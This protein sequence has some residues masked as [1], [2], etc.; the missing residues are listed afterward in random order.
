MAYRARSR[1]WLVIVAALAVCGVIA[2]PAAAQT[3][4]T[5]AIAAASVPSSY[6]EAPGPHAVT[7][8]QGGPD[9]TLYYPTNLG[10]GGTQHP[11][12]IWGNGTGATPESYDAQLRHLAT[13]GFVVAAANTT[14]SGSGQE[15]LAGAR[16]LIAEDQRSGSVFYGKI[17]ETKIGAAGHS[18]GGGGTIAAGADPIVDTTIPIQPGPQGSVP[19]LKG[20]SL[21]VAGQYDY[22]VPSWYVKSRYSQAGHVPAIFAELRGSDHF[23]PGETRVRLIGVVTAWFRFWL[24]ADEQARGIFFGPASSCGI[25]NDRAAWSAVARNSRAQAIPG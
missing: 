6:Y 23:F 1:S 24:A 8:V 2:S 5:R 21:F 16:F 19:Q 7:K 10:A 14:Q 9:H 17:D 11:V 20:P 22:I 15:M 12:L 4:T 25:C 3:Q 13:W 18:Q